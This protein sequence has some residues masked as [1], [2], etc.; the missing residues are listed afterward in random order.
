L[1]ERVR[2]QTVVPARQ[3]KGKERREQ[4]GYEGSA[5][6]GWEDERKKKQNGALKCPRRK[7]GKKR[8][9]QGPR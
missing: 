1:I 2:K 7:H 6:W 5:G 4:K 3:S 9:V 8:P